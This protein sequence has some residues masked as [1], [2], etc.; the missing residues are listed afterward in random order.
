ME[1]KAYSFPSFLFYASGLALY[2]LYQ[3]ELAEEKGGEMGT[4]DEMMAYFTF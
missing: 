1:S 3:G 2:Y 4:I